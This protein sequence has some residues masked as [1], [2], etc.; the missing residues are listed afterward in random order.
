MIKAIKYID[1]FGEYKRRTLKEFTDEKT[2]SGD[3]VILS[4][5]DRFRNRL[6]EIIGI[7]EGLI[8]TYPILDTLKMLERSFNLS[9]NDIEIEE[10]IENGQTTNVINISLSPKITKEDISNIEHRMSVYGYFNAESR[11]SDGKYIMSFEPK[12]TGNVRKY[13]DHK[14][15]YLMHVTLS[16]NMPK[17]MKYGLVP[18]S[19]NGE[20][21]LRHP[22]RIYFAIPENIDAYGERALFNVMAER[23]I[24]KRRVNKF[25]TPKFS[26][27]TID[28]SEVPQDVEFYNDPMFPQAIF[29][30]GNIPPSAIVNVKEVNFPYN[31]D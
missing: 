10:Y 5:N 1:K 8:S 9:E 17:I 22:E 14:Y 26:I 13:I 6:N 7:R 20:S 19:R 23:Y 30:Y 15:R 29:I 24:E 4:R 11:F 27:L 25:T 16:D 3:Y 31:G 18:R 21:D 28:I 2:I 12:Y